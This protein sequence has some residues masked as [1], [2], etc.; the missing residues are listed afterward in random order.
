MLTL[1]HWNPHWECF[2][3]EPTCKTGAVTAL[4]TLLG[5]TYGIKADFF[6]VIE[7]E[8]DNYVP[9]APYMLIGNFQSCGHDWATLIYNN[10]TWALASTPIVGCL[11]AGRSFAA[12]TFTRRA[13]AAGA[14]LAVVAAH[15]P[16]TQHNASAYAEATASLR[17]A[18]QKLGPAAMTAVLA[19]TN[20][21]SP[22]AAAASAWHNTSGGVNRTNAELMRDLGLWTSAAAPPAA[23]LFP[24]CCCTPFFAGD[25]PFSWEGDR[26]LA[27]AGNVDSESTL[28]DP[29]PAWACSDELRNATGSEFHKGVMLRLSGVPV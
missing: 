17:G 23:K 10:A 1:A 13:A 6:S 27:T 15:F 4:D 19:D 24:G 3:K 2:A 16:Q 5:P 11:A 26:I 29:A 8:V 20:T 18:L 25:T 22:S 28:F 12:A 21:E 14:E 7:F 9:P